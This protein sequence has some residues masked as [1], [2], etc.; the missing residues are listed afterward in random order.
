M[1]VFPYER[2][3]G[4]GG[5]VVSMETLKPSATGSVVYL[6]VGKDLDAALE[7]VWNA[8]GKVALEKTALPGDMGHFAHIID[9]EGNR[10]GLHAA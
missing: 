7:R 4:I 8:G 6:Y 2:E 1:A 3:S 9:S 5:C 10:V